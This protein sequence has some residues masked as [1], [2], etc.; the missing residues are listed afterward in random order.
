MSSPPGPRTFFITGTDTGVGKTTLTS[1]LLQHLRRR[2]FPALALKPFCAGSRADAELFWTLQRGELGLN[3]I[4][5]FY[6]PEPVAPFVAGRL[7]R[8]GVPL[9]AVI[10]HIEGVRLRFPHCSHLLIEGAGGLF[11]PL[12]ERYTVL[13]LIVALACEVV[14]VAANK[15]GTINHTLLTID[16]L[17]RA[18]A[19]ASLRPGIKENPMSRRDAP[20]RKNQRMSLAVPNVVLMN[21]SQDDA[22]SASNPAVIQ[23]FLSAVPVRV[24]PYLGPKAGSVSAVKR[25]EK[26]FQ[27]TLARILN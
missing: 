24:V 16:A 7:H 25:N 11:V 17:R 21:Q 14:V 19:P 9:S 4:N 1:L 20:A 8:K 3:E 23:H 10:R 13:D 26:K 22:S 5:P 2:G 15:L 18:G 12:G 6:F 27:K